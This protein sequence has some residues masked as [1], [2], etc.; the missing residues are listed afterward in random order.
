MRQNYQKYWWDWIIIN[1]SIIDKTELSEI[2]YF[3]WDKIIRNISIIDET[4]LSELFQL[5]MRQ[6]YQNYFNYW[7]DRNQ[8]YPVTRCQ[9]HPTLLY[10][11]S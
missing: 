9:N 3:W 1:I 11:L 8:C 7:W 10:S 5:L 6:N 2:F 4:K